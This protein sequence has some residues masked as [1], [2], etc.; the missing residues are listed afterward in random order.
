MKVQD[1]SSH[2]K[3]FLN[4]KLLKL[5]HKITDSFPLVQP[6]TSMIKA[7]RDSSNHHS[8]AQQS[9]KLLSSLPNN[10]WY[11]LQTNLSFSHSSHQF[12]HQFLRELFVMKALSWLTNLHNMSEGKMW[13]LS[14]C[15]IMYLITRTV[16]THKT[17]ATG[18]MSQLSEGLSSSISHLTTL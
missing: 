16:S 5:F 10:Q 9:F 8:F 15:L 6:L 17:L 4:R 7:F 12:S 13:C 18:A 14:I 11:N 1:T 3:I 2:Q